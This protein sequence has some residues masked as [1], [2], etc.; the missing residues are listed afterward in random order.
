MVGVGQS[1][2]LIMVDDGVPIPLVMVDDGV[3]IP[4]I[5]VDDGVPIPLVVVDVGQSIPLIM[6][7]EGMPV[8]L[9]MADGGRS[10]PLVVVGEGRPSTAASC[11]ATS[12]PRMPTLCRARRRDRVVRP[13][14]RGLLSSTHAMDAEPAFGTTKRPGRHSMTPPHRATSP[15]ARRP[16]P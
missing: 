5:M 16:R 7:G 10:I 2:P 3:P 8:P 14:P 11:T 13:H 9:V 4:L 15:H 12:K 6:V 1:I